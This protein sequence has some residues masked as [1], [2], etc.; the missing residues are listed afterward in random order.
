VWHYH[1]LRTA[2]YAE[3]ARKVGRFLH[4]HPGGPGVAE[5]RKFNA[6]YERTKN[7]YLETF[8]EEPPSE[9]WPGGAKSSGNLAMVIELLRSLESTG[10]STRLAA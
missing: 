3:F 6:Q 7:F 2:A 5:N 4:H 10:D 9:F 1:I 8:G